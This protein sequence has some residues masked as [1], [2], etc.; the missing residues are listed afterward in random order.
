MH[1]PLPHTDL[2]WSA[3]FRHPPWPQVYKW[4][5][6]NNRSSPVAQLLISQATSD[7]DAASEAL[8]QGAL[9]RAMANAFWSPK[10]LGDRQL[11]R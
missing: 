4:P 7:L 6:S 2:F 10:A 1:T 11:V 8:V 5:S 3:S 9:D